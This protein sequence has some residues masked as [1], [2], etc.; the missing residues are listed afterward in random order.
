MRKNDCILCLFSHSVVFDSLRPH[1]QQHA[2]LPCPI[3]QSL[4]KLMS[5]ESV[6]PSNHLILCHPL[7][8]GFQSFPASGSF[9]MS[10]LFASGQGNSI[11]QLKLKTSCFH[12]FLTL[13]QN[14]MNCL[15][16]KRPFSY[17]ANF[18]GSSTVLPV[19]CRRMCPENKSFSL[20]P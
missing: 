6:M 4:L 5:I 16:K 17:L 20:S 3:S 19:V 1:E 18:H 12:Q 15:N 14:I 11:V 9:P 13:F 7:L 10:W 8:F 2:R